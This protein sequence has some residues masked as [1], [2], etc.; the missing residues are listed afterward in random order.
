MRMKKLAIAGAILA[1][2]GTYAVSAQALV[3]WPEPAPAVSY[4]FR[5][6][7]P[8]PVTLLPSWPPLTDPVISDPPAATYAPA[9]DVRHGRRR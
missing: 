5:K 3:P 8:P 1:A 2:A 6:A 4:G 7:S 9:T